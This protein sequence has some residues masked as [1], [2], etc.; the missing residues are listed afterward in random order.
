MPGADPAHIQAGGA[1]RRIALA[2]RNSR[3]G[4]DDAKRATAMAITG[5]AVRTS[6]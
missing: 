2:L 4:V 3:L 1:W 6:W 5:R